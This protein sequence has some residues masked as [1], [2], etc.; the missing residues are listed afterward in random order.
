MVSV[1][2]FKEEP[3]CWWLL[4]HHLSQALVKV[5]LQLAGITVTQQLTRR[6]QH[7]AVVIHLPG[8]S[9]MQGAGRGGGRKI[10]IGKLD[11]R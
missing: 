5:P 9:K 3:D 10:N 2:V 7:A 4:L 6:G 1:L 8:K 11:G